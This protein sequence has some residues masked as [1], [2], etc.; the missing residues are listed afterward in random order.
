MAKPTLEQQRAKDAWRK[1]GGCCREYMTLAKAL[2]GLIMNSGLM[3]TMAFLHQKGGGKSSNHHRKL[4]ED[5]R[6]WL[7]ERFPGEVKE[8]FEEFMYGL[9]KADPRT[10][11]DITVEAMAWLRW[12]RQ[13]AAARCGDD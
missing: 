11:Q 13:M 5:L 7:S 8:D 9:M 3:Q 10:Y 4:A 1:S 6:S 2:P 12:M